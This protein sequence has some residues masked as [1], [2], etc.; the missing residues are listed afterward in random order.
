MSFI[1]CLFENVVLM[2]DRTF[3]LQKLTIEL[4]T[5][6]VVRTETG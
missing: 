2:S 1:F 5:I 6:R 4:I 3:K